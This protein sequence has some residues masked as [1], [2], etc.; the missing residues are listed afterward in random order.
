MPCVYGYTTTNFNNIVKKRVSKKFCSFNL[1][2]IGGTVC[3]AQAMVHSC[4]IAFCS[5]IALLALYIH[6][7]VLYMALA[8]I[9]R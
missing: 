1:I 6:M 5:M 3:Y 7:C 4:I 9:G 2:R 8:L